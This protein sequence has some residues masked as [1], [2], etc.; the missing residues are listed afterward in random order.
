MA[1]VSKTRKRTRRASYADNPFDALNETGIVTL[2]LSESIMRIAQDVPAKIDDIEDFAW[3]LSTFAA[4]IQSA[5]MALTLYASSNESETPV[6]KYMR[7]NKVF[8]NIVEQSGQILKQIRHLRGP[9]KSL[10]GY[11]PWLTKLRW[12]FCAGDVQSLG[13]KLQS[14]KNTMS[15]ILSTL[16]LE[17]AYQ[18]E[19]RTEM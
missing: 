17:D 3:E 7:A 9:L 1:T 4:A 16:A 2:R 13:T 14:I 10:K 15:L 8:Y 5:H 19:D 6:L 12:V 11:F 18:R